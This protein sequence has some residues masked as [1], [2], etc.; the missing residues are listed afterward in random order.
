MEL[1][2]YELL[3]RVAER[4]GDARV[5]A[6]AERIGADERAMADRVGDRWDVA[7]EASLREKDADDLRAE[8]VKY[9]RDAHAL[10]AQALQMLEAAPALANVEPLTR[11]LME[12]L[13]ETRKHQELVD[14]RLSAL[15]ARPA[16]FQAG[17]LRGGALNLGAFFKAQPD[18][19][20]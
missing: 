14:E 19:P 12:H 13:A 6:L 10:E 2:A 3:R 9:L 4:A 18:T 17:V 15:G 8:L 20:V 7:V 5:V 16:R 11:V 1:A